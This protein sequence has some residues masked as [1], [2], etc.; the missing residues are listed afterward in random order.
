MEDNR[1]KTILC[2][3]DGV[4]FEHC[5][6]ITKQSLIEPKVLDGVLDKIREWDLKGYKIILV[7]GRRES[8]RKNTEEQLAR[9]GIIYDQLVMGVSGGVRVL[10][11]DRKPNKNFDTAL[12]V[13]LERN[14]G[15]KDVDI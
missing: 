4:L 15:L 2:D 9:A 1:P 12:S 8:T 10:I 5:G 7:T 6:D 13:N 11:N 14:S 3:I